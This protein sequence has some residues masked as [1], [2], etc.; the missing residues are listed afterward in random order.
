MDRIIPA[1][2]FG[3]NPKLKDGILLAGITNRIPVM[4]EK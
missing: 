4:W 2:P 3:V 1:R